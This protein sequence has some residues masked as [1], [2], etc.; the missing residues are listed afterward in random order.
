MIL[1]TLK[2]IKVVMSQL[3]LLKCIW[4]WIL[5][6]MKGRVNPSHVASCRQKLTQKE[7]KYLTQTAEILYSFQHKAWKTQPR[8]VHKTRS[9]E[10]LQFRGRLSFQDVSVF[11]LA[12][13]KKHYSFSAFWCWPPRPLPRFSE[14]CAVSP[15]RGRGKNCPCTVPCDVGVKCCQRHPSRLTLMCCWLELF[16]AGSQPNHV[17][18]TRPLGLEVGPLKSFASSRCINKIRFVQEKKSMC[19]L[20]G[21]RGRASDVATEVGSHNCKSK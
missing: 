6:N 13:V 7:F 20:V 3:I 1:Y 9:L 4:F 18:V 8:Y 16:G 14:S 10:L 2:C 11:S 15:S 12:S 21:S 17:R 19:V 5:H